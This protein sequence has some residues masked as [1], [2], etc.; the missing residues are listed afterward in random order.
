[1]AAD[2][3]EDEGDGTGLALEL[4]VGSGV[5][6]TAGKPPLFPHPEKPIATAAAR[7]RKARCR[8]TGITFGSKRSLPAI[9]G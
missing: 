2:V 5:L 9:I 7:I 4:T 8:F 3:T 1:M 6:T